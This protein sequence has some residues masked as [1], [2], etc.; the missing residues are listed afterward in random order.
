[1]EQ[2]N[3]EV[4]EKDGVVYTDSREVAELVEKDHK[5]LLR[6]IEKYKKVILRSSTLSVVNYFVE[7]TYLSGNNQKYKNYLLTEKGC[8]MVANKMTGDKG[9]LF[10]ATYIDA[11]HN[12]RKHIEQQQYQ[13]P[14][15]PMQALE[16][17]FNVQKEQEE[18]NKQMQHEI[19]G[20]RSIVGLN[21]TDW[22]K[23][24]NKILASIVQKLGGGDYHET[25]RNKAY[26]QLEN[27]AHCRLDQRL[28]N[29][30]SNMLAQG[31]GKSKIKQIKKIDVIAED[32]RLIE[33]YLSVVKDLAI[34]YGLNIDELN[35]GGNK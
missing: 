16:L 3:L 30:K 35:I 4:F 11:F 28:N 29:R 23:D 27:K 10:T 19:T 31:L 22:R 6:D 17:M 20:I 2:L 5:N 32:N 34:H 33:I 1:M 9:I 24:T 13:V 14:Q 12:M 18:F 25:I 8:D 15:T 7:T 26:K 21:T